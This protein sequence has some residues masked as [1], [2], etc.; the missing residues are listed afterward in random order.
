MTCEDLP[1]CRPSRYSPY[2]IAPIVRGDVD[3]ILFD[4]DGVLLDTEPLYARAWNTYLSRF[5]YELTHELQSKMMGRPAL[6]S[7]GLVIQEFRLPLTPEL[8]V[9]Q[10]APILEALIRK[11]P[12]F[13]GAAELVAEL[14]AQGFPLAVA[15]STVAPLF[16][17]KTFEHSWFSNFDCIVCGDDPQVF[18]PKPAP[19]IFLVAAERLGARP[20]RCVIFE[21]S[22]AG[23]QA[24]QQTGARVIRVG[25]DQTPNAIAPGEAVSNLLAALDGVRRGSTVDENRPGVR[26]QTRPSS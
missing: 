5:G 24:A 2:M 25:G 15:T 20:E 17:L 10:R 21:D 23:L 8:L 26:M 4:M 19:D 14:R 7:A 16:R 13:P 18:K 12:A 22:P 1:R 6:V 11:S 3:A 9:E